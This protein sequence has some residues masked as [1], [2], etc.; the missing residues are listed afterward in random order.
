MAYFRFYEELNDFLPAEKRKATFSHQFAASASI[1]DIIESLG[2]PHT[3]IDLILVNGKSIDFSYL[4]QEG[5]RVSVYPVFEAVDI[6]PVIKLRPSP[7]RI[8]RFILDV[9]LGKLA[10][11]LRLLGFD[12]LYDTDYKDDEIISIAEKE[13]RIILTRD[14]GLLKNKKVTHGYWMRETSPKKQV[15]EVFNRFDLARQCRPFS[16]CLE[17]NGEIITLPSDPAILK[18][19]PEKVKAVQTDF[20]QCSQ[21]SR[22]YWQG[23]HY[24]KLRAVVAEFLHF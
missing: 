9:H 10:R 14:I 22:L 19:I 11:Y 23:T 12:T 20:Y 18:T 5:D 15:K 17:C 8:T 16:R 13:K 7:L 24:N 3:E 2:V 1:K 6:T 21:C 4:L